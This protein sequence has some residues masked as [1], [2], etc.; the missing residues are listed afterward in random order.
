[1]ASPIISA[2]VLKRSLMAQRSRLTSPLG[3]EKVRFPHVHVS[4]QIFFDRMPVFKLSIFIHPRSPGPS[5]GT[6]YFSSWRC[7]HTSLDKWWS[8]SFTHHEIRYWSQTLRWAAYA[9]TWWHFPPRSLLLLIN[10]YAYTCHPVFRWR[11]VG[12]PN[13]RHS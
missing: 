1:M 13:Q 6:I 7:P 5:R 12:H 9:K 10:A 2:S 11:V 8:R 4:N 3:P